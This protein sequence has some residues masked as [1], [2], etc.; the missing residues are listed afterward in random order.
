MIKNRF[1]SLLL[2][3]P[4]LKGMSERKIIRKLL[5]GPPTQEEKAKEQGFKIVNLKTYHS[6]RMEGEEAWGESMVEGAPVASS[7]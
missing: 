2:R 5:A 7:I 1:K 6:E 3:H 4:H